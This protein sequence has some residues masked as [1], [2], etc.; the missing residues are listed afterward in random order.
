MEKIFYIIATLLIAV[1]V[2]AQSPCLKNPCLNGGHCVMTDTDDYKCICSNYYSGYNCEYCKCFI[3]TSQCSS[4]GDGI[5]K[6]KLVS[7]EN[8]LL[9]LYKYI[10]FFK[11]F[12]VRINFYLFS[13]LL[14]QNILRAI[15]SGRKYFTFNIAYFSNCIQ[16]DQLNDS[17]V[18][19]SY[20]LYIQST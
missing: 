1:N 6:V 14:S 17:Y 11:L 13:I 10:F 2:S 9:Y 12:L 4:I 3:S 19:C 18:F 20:L 16:T 5:C 15:E 8:G 7:K